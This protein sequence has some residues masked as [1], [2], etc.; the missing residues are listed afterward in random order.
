MCAHHLPVDWRMRIA[1][2]IGV[3]MMN[4]VG[5]HPEDRSALK[6]QRSAESQEIFHPLVSLVSAMCEQPVIAHPD[7]Q[8]P[9]EPPQENR[10]EKGFPGKKEKCCEGAHMKQRHESRCHP[11]HFV[12]C[13]VRFAKFFELHADDGSPF[14]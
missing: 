6:R 7:A 8:T 14:P 13:G 5:R 3:L 9:A 12:F 2:L 10:Q 4:P 1:L 11:V